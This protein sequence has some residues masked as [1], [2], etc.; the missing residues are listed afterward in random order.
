MMADWYQE[1]FLNTLGLALSESVAQF[2]GV[3]S[4]A[5][6]YTFNSGN[7]E[8]ECTIDVFDDDAEGNGSTELANKF[9]HMPVE[10]RELAQHFG[11]TNL[12]TSSLVDVIEDRLRMCEEHIL[13]SISLSGKP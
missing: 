12:P 10:V 3:P 11:D 2:A 13:H 8:T 6:S 7:S 5:V 9:F 1:V 4:D